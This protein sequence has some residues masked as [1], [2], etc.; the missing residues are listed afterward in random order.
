MYQHD[1]PGQSLI[2]WMHFRLCPCEIHHLCS[3]VH[4]SKMY[5]GSQSA[6]G[7]FAQKKK[8]GGRSVERSGRHVERTV[9]MSRDLNVTLREVDVT[10]REV[11]VMSREV[12]VKLR[13]LD[14]TW[15][16]LDVMSRHLDIMSIHLDT[17]LD[18]SKNGMSYIW[19]H[20]PPPCGPWGDLSS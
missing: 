14:V 13:E 15:R 8:S 11:D 1:V 17:T 4:T 3:T 12:D 2:L 5:S 16:N 7:T 6:N 19:V 20:I 18:L 10:L 9:V